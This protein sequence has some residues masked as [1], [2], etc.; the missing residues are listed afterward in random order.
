ML[1]WL[2][3]PCTVALCKPVYCKSHFCPSGTVVPL[4]T[5]IY[6]TAEINQVCWRSPL[7]D[8]DRDGCEVAD[9]LAMSETDPDLGDRQEVDV[10]FGKSYAGA[11]MV[12]AY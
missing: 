10:V 2:I 1:R 11:Y 9:I 6:G 8:T 4:K 7:F 5:R 3:T 12:A